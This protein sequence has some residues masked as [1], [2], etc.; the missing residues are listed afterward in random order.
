APITVL[1]ICASWR[2]SGESGARVLPLQARAVLVVQERNFRPDWDFKWSKQNDRFKLIFDAF[3]CRWDLY[4]MEKDKPLL[5]K[6]TLN[7]TAYGTMMMVP[8]YWSLD[9]HRDIKWDVA[10]RLHRA[11]GVFRQGPKMSSNRGA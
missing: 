7:I 10:G 6:F 3:C 8:R 4:G 9:G 2:C 1:F 11:R 5:L